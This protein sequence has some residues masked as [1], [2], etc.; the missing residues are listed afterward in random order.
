MFRVAVFIENTSVLLL[1]TGWNEDLMGNRF[2][3]LSIIKVLHI[4]SSWTTNG[5]LFAASTPYRS[6]GVIRWR[7]I[8]KG[9]CS[10][11]V[12]R[13]RVSRVYAM[14][15]AKR[16]TMENGEE[17]ERRKWSPWEERGEGIESR[18]KAK[19][20]LSMSLSFRSRMLFV[21]VL[22]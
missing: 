3:F 8:A 16:N 14:E 22:F 20:T 17:L 2:C 6:T 13:K 12:A 10:G 11:K 4:P 15:N 7:T 9:K 1:S 18:G 5:Q 21:S 19:K